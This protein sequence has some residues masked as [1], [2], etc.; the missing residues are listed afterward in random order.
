MNDRI[1][2]KW[3]D[4]TEKQAHA[5]AKREKRNTG[6]IKITETQ[7]VKCV[8]DLLS[9]HKVFAWRNNSGAMVTERGN[10]IRFG[11]KGSPDIIAVHS[12]KFYGIE[13]KVGNNKLSNSQQEF[14]KKIE[15]AGG[16]YWTIW[17]LEQAQDVI[18]IIK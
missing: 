12:G 10:F 14:Q 1:T 3:K 6:V 17:T 8:L 11:A 7:L 13:C 4:E 9:A 5:L 18:N 2:Q 15:Q 16:C